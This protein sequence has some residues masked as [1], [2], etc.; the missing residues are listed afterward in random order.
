MYTHSRSQVRLLIHGGRYI[1]VAG[2]PYRLR[3][4]A[5]VDAARQLIRSDLGDSRVQLPVC[6][7]ERLAS[8]RFRSHLAD[9]RLKC[10]DVLNGSVTRSICV[11]EFFEGISNRECVGD[12]GRILASGQQCVPKAN[13]V[14]DLGHKE[15][16]STPRSNIDRP[17]FGQEPSGLADRCSPQPGLLAQLIHCRD[18]VAGLEVSV[19]DDSLDV[20]RQ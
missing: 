2:E 12:T 6:R 19:D 10:V 9:D 16:T 7:H 20:G 1:C 13:D 17:A 15:P 3:H 8:R 11:D 14:A 18:A 4:R 5:E